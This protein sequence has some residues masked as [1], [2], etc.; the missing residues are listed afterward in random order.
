MNL[1]VFRFSLARL[2]HIRPI[3][4]SLWRRYA[5]DSV[6]AYTIDAAPPPASRY[7]AQ[8]ALRDFIQGENMAVV[9]LGVTEIDIGKV[10]H[11]LT[12]LEH[13]KHQDRGIGIQQR[14]G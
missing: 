14:F 8:L 11:S 10:D 3:H 1:F 13:K 4:F 6:F 9:K 2:Y 7:R 12:I 5:A